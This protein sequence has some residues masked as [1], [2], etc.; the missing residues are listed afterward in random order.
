MRSEKRRLELIRFFEN[1]TLPCLGD[2]WQK[3]RDSRDGRSDGEPGWYMD[4]L[5]GDIFAT[6][7]PVPR[8][9]KEAER[10]R[11]EGLSFD[12]VCTINSPRCF[13]DAVFGMYLIYCPQEYVSAAHMA[14]NLLEKIERLKK[15]PGGTEIGPEYYKNFEQCHYIYLLE[16]AS[17]KKT[18]TFLENPIG[19]L[20]QIRQSIS[21]LLS[22]ASHIDESKWNEKLH[23]LMD[24]ISKD[25]QALSEKYFPPDDEPEDI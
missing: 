12:F 13:W 10:E 15:L 18:N 25:C 9:E 5:F 4:D 16:L 14:R 11:M 1:E 19:N 22:G 2:Y 6:H 20:C 21:L 7:V 24:K 17:G 23:A 3:V 8:N